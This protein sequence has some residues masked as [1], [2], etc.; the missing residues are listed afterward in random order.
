M[1]IASVTACLVRYRATGE[2]KIGQT[3]CSGLQR[4][5]VGISMDLEVQHIFKTDGV[6]EGDVLSR[7]TVVKAV[8]H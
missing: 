2:D 4:R 3:G 5:G 8:R 7:F 6:I 1:L